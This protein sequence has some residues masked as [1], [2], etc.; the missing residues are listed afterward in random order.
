MTHKASSRRHVSANRLASARAEFWCQSAPAGNTAAAARNG[1]KRMTA[2][3]SNDATEMG[4]NA[5]LRREMRGLRQMSKP[6]QH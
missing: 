5:C 2:I 4:G 6:T 3:T 1:G